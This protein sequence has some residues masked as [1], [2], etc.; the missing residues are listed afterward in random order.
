MLRG[1]QKLTHD[2]IKIKPNTSNAREKC[3]IGKYSW[4][5]EIKTFQYAHTQTNIR[6]IG[7]VKFGEKA[8]QK[9]LK[10]KIW[11]SQENWNSTKE[12]EVASYYSFILLTGCCLY[13]SKLTL[14][15]TGFRSAWEKKKHFQ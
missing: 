1:S 5:I 13:T 7:K 4:L 10:R 3:Q 15:E 14:Y 11:I 12:K 8:R 9:E 2:I 6:I